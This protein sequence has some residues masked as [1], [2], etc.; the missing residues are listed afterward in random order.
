MRGIYTAIPIP[1]CAA[2]MLINSGEGERAAL[3]ICGSRLMGDGRP[4]A[5]IANEEAFGA[6]VQVRI[7]REVASAEINKSSL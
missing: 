5:R 7:I 1:M 4:S 2:L 3:V 6:Q